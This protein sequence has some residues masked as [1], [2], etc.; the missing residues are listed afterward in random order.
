MMVK[1]CLDEQKDAHFVLT[2]VRLQRKPYNLI[3]RMSMGD[4]V[5]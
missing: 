2:N 5:G 1:E 3:A 4:Y